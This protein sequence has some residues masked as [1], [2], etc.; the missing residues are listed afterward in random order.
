MP[1]YGTFF[2][3]I[4][5][6][7]QLNVDGAQREV[8]PPGAPTSG[9]TTSLNGGFRSGARNR[10]YWAFQWAAASGSQRGDDARGKASDG[11]LSGRY[12][13]T[14]G[15]LRD[16]KSVCR[17]ATSG[18]DRSFIGRDASTCG[19]SCHVRAIG[20]L[21]L[22]KTTAGLDSSRRQA[23]HPAP[24]G[25]SP[26]RESSSQSEMQHPLRRSRP[27][28]ER[29]YVAQSIDAVRRNSGEEGQ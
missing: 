8:R 16:E 29:L 18:L 3:L 5:K 13:P 1:E 28:R 6:D 14:R 15:P 19:K 7:R 17:A 26:K 21:L 24:I 10:L 27:S 2:D 9:R 4:S 12:R 23:H 20:P 11:Q 25:V 22:R